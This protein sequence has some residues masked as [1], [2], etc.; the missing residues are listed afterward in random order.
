MDTSPEIKP[1]GSDFVLEVEA[2]FVLYE[3]EIWHTCFQYLPETLEQQGPIF[4]C[5]NLRPDGSSVLEKSIESTQTGN[6]QT[7]SVQSPKIPTFEQRTGANHLMIIAHGPQIAVYVNGEPVTLVYD[8]QSR[9]T[10]ITLLVGTCNLTDTTLRVHFDNFKVWDISNLPLPTP[11]PR[12]G[13]VEDGDLLDEVMAAGKIVVSSDPNYAPQSFLNDD[14]ELDGFDVDVA[15]EVANRLGVE[16][17]FITPDWNMITSGG[18]AG[19]W[20]LSIGSM[21]ITEARMEALL[22]TQPY[23]FAPAQVVVHMDN[24]DIQQVDDL[25]GKTIGV[26]DGCFYEHWLR[27]TLTLVGEEVVLPGWEAGNIVV[28]TTELEAVIDLAEGDGDW[29]DAMISAKPMLLD[30][31]ASGCDGGCPFRLVGDPVYNEPMAFALDKSR[32][33]SE[34]MLERLNQILTDMHVDGTLTELS[35]KWYGVEYTKRVG[36]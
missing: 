15:K 20:D 1:L 9:K 22:F 19:R 35:M 36:E 27:G 6:V 29:L 16:L 13:T 33:P 8:E 17:E 31:I 26:C 34:R 11:A 3:R 21:T 25:A 28:Y 32:G 12:L 14:G 10:V 23:Y 2:Q 30:A 4:Y 24:T 7:S 5:V 18:W